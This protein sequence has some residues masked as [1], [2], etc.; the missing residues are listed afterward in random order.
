MDI[1]YR[2]AKYCTLIVSQNNESEKVTEKIGLEQTVLPI[3]YG[4][5]VK[6]KKSLVNKLPYM[7]TKTES[8]NKCHSLDDENIEKEVHFFQRNML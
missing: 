8:S 3:S 4:D 2:T 7:Q 5:V 1:V 6:D